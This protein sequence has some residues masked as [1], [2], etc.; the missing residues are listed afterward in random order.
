MNPSGV[1]SSSTFGRIQTAR[2]GRV[3]Q[4]GLKYLF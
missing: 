4:F 3:M 2:D 1:F